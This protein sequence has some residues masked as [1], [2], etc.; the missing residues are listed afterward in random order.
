MLVLSDYI[1]KNTPDICQLAVCWNFKTSKFPFPHLGRHA[2]K[3]QSIESSGNRG[4]SYGH[5][6][7]VLYIQ[8][9]IRFD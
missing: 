8:R 5:M 7:L 4:S 3:E 6:N 1:C 2:Y 9:H